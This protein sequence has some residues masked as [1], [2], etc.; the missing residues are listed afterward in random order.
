MEKFGNLWLARLTAVRYL[1]TLKTTEVV[2]S[3]ESSEWELEDK[4]EL[5]PGLW[6]LGDLRGGVTRQPQRDRRIEPAPLSAH[7]MSQMSC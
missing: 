3:R 4:P 5:W 6:K 1:V 7:G 2:Q